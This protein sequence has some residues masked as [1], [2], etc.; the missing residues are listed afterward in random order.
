[1]QGNSRIDVLAGF[2][3]ACVM[4]ASPMTSTAQELDP[5]PAVIAR[6]AEQSLLLD[7]IELER[8]GFVAVGERGHILLSED[9]QQWKQSEHVPVRSTLTRVTAFGRQLWAVGH[10]SAI[11]HSADGGEHWVLQH[12][13]PEASEPLLDV[14]FTSS[15]RGFAVGAYGRFMA[16]NDGGQSW[17]V[18]RLAD[19]IAGEDI[20]WEAIARKQGGYDTLP[21]DYEFP[22]GSSPVDLL[23]K[24]CYEFQECHLNAILALGDGRLMLAAERGYGFRSEDN[25]ES[26]VAFRFPY[27]GSMFG[28]IESDACIVAFGLRGHI[29]RS[30]DFGQRWEDL[31]TPNE[32]ALMDGAQLNGQVVLVG[33]G[34]TRIYLDGDG[35]MELEADRLGSDYAGVT[36]ASGGLLLVGEDG[37]RYETR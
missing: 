2:V 1:M 26:W 3:L 18:E 19:R 29:Q 14:L 16:T 12:Y 6:L 32:Q 8:S 21:D 27:P 25:G 10:D 34:A 17:Q 4:F 5:E 33:A 15:S 30:C 22:D 11:L 13:E 23:D 7:V 28:L 37:V 31:N 9:G 24:G 20:D 36:A 35:S